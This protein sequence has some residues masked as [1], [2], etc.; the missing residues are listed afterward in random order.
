M[1]E[2]VPGNVPGLI[3]AATQAPGQTNQP[4]SPSGS[5]GMTAENLQAMSNAL[6]KIGVPL[7]GQ[8]ETKP[9]ADALQALDLKQA[10]TELQK[11]ANQSDTLS[12]TAK[13][14]LAQAVQ[15][16]APALDQA[17]L[18]GLSAD[19]QASAT[20]LKDPTSASAP[21]KDTLNKAAGD[22]SSLAAQ[23]TGQSAQGQP[24]NTPGQGA[25]QG[26]AGE[27]P[28]KGNPLAIARLGGE[29]NSFEIPNGASSPSGILTAGAP[30]GAPVGTASGA[31]DLSAAGGDTVTSLL[32]PYYYP[33]KYQNVVSSY[34]QPPQ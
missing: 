24:G 18:K 12:Q 32:E 28:Q 17:G 23:L 13:D 34:F 27:V 33:W 10:A 3:A 30:N 5:G 1:A 4:S 14:Q 26:L 22:L 7:S 31:L 19:L 6:Q 20:A 25:A 15:S 11:L 16:A 9:L 21:L 2:V 29:A 8:A